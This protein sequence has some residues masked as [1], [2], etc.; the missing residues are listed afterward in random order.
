MRRAAAR[1]LRTVCHL[2]PAQVAHRIRLAIRRG[3]WERLGPRVEARYRARATGFGRPRLDHPGLAAV[4]HYRLARAPEEERLRIARDALAGRFT[5][6]G[7]TEDLGRDVAWHRPDLDAGTRL[8][9]T[10]LHEFPYAIDLAA[11][12]RA[13]GD[14]L[15][16]AR[17]SE[18]VASWEA[19]SPIARPG[20]A[21]DCWNARAVATRLANLALAGSLLEDE[22]LAE[23]LGPLLA[24]HALFLRENLELDLGANHL[25]RDTAGLVFAHEL[26]G[27]FAD[28]LPLLREQIE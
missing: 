14:A 11:A 19:A 18:L 4:A 5:F 27:G 21:I 28:G 26:F 25:M 2:R 3:A 6:L 12:A 10:Q 23:A 7:R 9:K 8:W 15:F 22:G 17:L 16:R 1:W 24:R 13:T 20:F